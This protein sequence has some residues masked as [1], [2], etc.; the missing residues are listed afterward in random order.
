MNYNS[1]LLS[2][3]SSFGFSAAAKKIATKAPRHKGSP[4]G[5]YWPLRTRRDAKKKKKTVKISGL[6]CS[7]PPAAA[8]FTTAGVMF[9]SAAVMFATVAAMFAS[10]GAMFKSAVTM[11][12]SAAAMFKSASAMF[13]TAVTMFTS[14]A[15]VFASAGAMFK[16]AVTKFKTA[17]VN[18]ALFSAN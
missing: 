5:F 11:F 18:S 13:A 1:I 14:A 10:A 7:V 3:F 9:K 15:A 4:R 2:Q 16:S 12:T 17:A 8:M 6:P